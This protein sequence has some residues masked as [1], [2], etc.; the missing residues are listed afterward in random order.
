MTFK[1]V[2]F[3]AIAIATV[4]SLP[5]SASA[6]TPAGFTIT[7][8]ITGLPDKS[9]VYIT[10]GNK[11]GDTLARSAVKGGHFVLKGTV[12]E[13]NLFELNLAGIKK[14]APVFIGNDVAGIE[15]S[16]TALNELKITGSP[17]HADFVAFQEVF[18]PGFQQL[19]AIS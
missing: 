10:D 6:Q 19:N 11:P 17:S 7:G 14:K 4:F 9:M 18:N 5:L 1:P 12:T 3:S 13:P 8:H 2:L 15:G 16:S